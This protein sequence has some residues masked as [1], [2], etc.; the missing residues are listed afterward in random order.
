[1]QRRARRRSLQE[2]RK[3]TK[4]NRYESNR[5]LRLIQQKANLN[6]FERMKA[7][8][9]T[10]EEAV[11]VNQ[12]ALIDKIL[13]RYSTELTLFREL[14]QNANDAN[15]RQLQI[16]F[17]G[18]Q[19]WSSLSSAGSSA[20]EAKENAGSSF[21]SLRICNDGFVFREEDWERIKSIADGQ[22]DETKTGFFG[23]GFY[24]V[25]SLAEEP[26]V[27]SGKKAMSFFWKEN[28]LFV[29]RG[30]PPKVADRGNQSDQA[31]L[32]MVANGWTVFDLPVRSDPPMPKLPTITELSDFLVRCLTFTT[33]LEKVDVFM[34]DELAL[35]VSRS[36]SGSRTSIST[37]FED[38]R[39][40]KSSPFKFATAVKEPL[41]YH[42]WRCDQ[43]SPVFI[44]MMR[45]KGEFDVQ[46][47]ERFK[48]S[49]HR[50]TKK[51][52]PQK[53]SLQL[54]FDDSDD[55]S[56][57]SSA[58][59]ELI[60]NVSAAST[61]GGF[62]FIGSGITQQSTGS[63]CHCEGPFMPTMER[64]AMDM[65]DPTLA[66]WNKGLIWATGFLQRVAF[67]FRCSELTRAG[68]NADAP[69]VKS[70][71][72]S[73]M[74][75]F[76]SKATTPVQEV[77]EICSA[78]FFT[79]SR[80]PPV[81]WTSTG[82]RRASEAR[83]N[84]RTGLSNFVHQT[85]SIVELPEGLKDG[86]DES[87]SAALAKQAKSAFEFFS[88]FL[89][90]SSMSNSKDKSG[91]TTKEPLV[92][93]CKRFVGDLVD[94]GY[95]RELDVR[96]LAKELHERTLK[97]DEETVDLLKWLLQR[98][99][100]AETLRKMTE[101]DE[102]ACFCDLCGNKLLVSVA[103]LR[104]EKQKKE[105]EASSSAT[106]LFN[107]M[108][109]TLT[110]QQ[111][112]TNVA[113]KCARC[114]HVVTVDAGRLLNSMD[115]IE[116]NS[117]YTNKFLLEQ[118]RFATGKQLSGFSFF[119]TPEM[120]KRIKLS[121][122]K[123]M[124]PRIMKNFW[125]ALSLSGKVLPDVVT[126]KFMANEVVQIDK[127]WVRPLPWSE[128]LNVCLIFDASNG[129]SDER[130]AIVSNVIR[131]LAFA[132]YHG[133]INSEVK[134]YLVSR[135]A[136]TH[137]IPVQSKQLVK[138]SE[139]YFSTESTGGFKSLRVVSFV[140]L[141]EGGGFA[142]SS[143]PPQDKA[144]SKFLVELGV[145]THVDLGFVFE[146]FSKGSLGWNRQEIL[147]YI[148][149]MRKELDSMEISRLQRMEF[150][151]RIE[152]REGKAYPSLKSSKASD[153]LFPSEEL[154][155]LDVPL[156][157]AIVE[158]GLPVKKDE[159]TTNSMTVFEAHEQ[160]LPNAARNL[161][162]ELGVGLHPE[163]KLLLRQAAKPNAAEMNRGALAYIIRHF[164]TFASAYMKVCSHI[165]FIPCK[166][167]SKKSPSTCFTNSKAALLAQAVI[168]EEK[169]S[170]K[171]AEMLGVRSDPDSREV[172][173]SLA[174]NPPSSENAVEVFEYIATQL[175][176]MTRTHLHELRSVA[177]I[178]IPEPGS[179]P[180]MLRYASPQTIF[181]K[182]SGDKPGKYDGLF[183]YVSFDSQAVNLFLRS[184][185]VRD[186][187]SVD[188][189]AKELCDG[190]NA[191][192]HVARVGFTKYLHVL[193]ML[194][195]ETT[196]ISS[197]TK[198]IMSKAKFL[199]GAQ[200]VSSK[201]KKV[202]DWED[203]ELSMQAHY[204]L[205]RPKDVYI[206]DNDV[207]D[208]MF[209][210]VVAPQENIL[211]NLY[212][213]LGSQSL[214]AAVREETRPGNPYAVDSEAVSL[215][216]L[217]RKRMQLF[218]FKR[219]K[220]DFV[221][222]IEKWLTVIQK[223]QFVF[224]VP[225]IEK[226][227]HF[228]GKIKKK[229]CTAYALSHKKRALIIT[230]NYS[231]FECSTEL[232]KVLLKKNTLHDNLL[233][234]TILQ[235][236]D[237]VLREQGF[238]V[239]RN[240]VAID[241][242]VEEV[243]TPKE[244]LVPEVV[245]QREE[246]RQPMTPKVQPKSLSAFEPVKEAPETRGEA[247]ENVTPPARRR[248]FRGWMN[249]M[250]SGKGKNAASA[251]ESAPARGKSLREIY[252]EQEDTINR[253]AEMSGK[254]SPE[255]KDEVMKQAS[256]TLESDSQQ[257]QVSNP[258]QGGG[259][260]SVKNDP[261]LNRSRRESILRA[262]LSRVN[263]GGKI[264]EIVSRAEQRAMAPLLDDLH[265]HN[266]RKTRFT[267]SGLDCF[268]EVGAGDEEIFRQKSV[269]ATAFSQM[270]LWISQN[271]FGIDDPL[272]CHIYFHHEG[273][274]GAFNQSGALYFNF[275]FFLV[276]LENTGSRIYSTL[277]SNMQPKF[278]VSP[279]C[280]IDWYGIF[281]HELAHNTHHQHDAAFANMMMIFFT[282]FV[283][284][285]NACLTKLKDEIK[286][287]I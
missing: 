12:R 263:D 11:T 173:N 213:S 106:G 183:P 221:R 17:Q 62:F 200:H 169:L 100:T 247:S 254:A 123:G 95:L 104:K 76:S 39:T 56:V 91:E 115:K 214:S 118:A 60:K 82:A 120:L 171:D 114:A 271:I 109:A 167:G 20:V 139:A 162:R 94:R 193:R 180:S 21:S 141:L 14:L 287:A 124:E 258:P 36:S 41:L 234:S 209:E 25:F 49:M 122:E 31:I 229:S 225:S 61:R 175:P 261:L 276:Q 30:S 110:G 184:V 151:P 228:N 176:K 279:D 43:D 125:E 19:F 190:R 165:D 257:S 230:A 102:I 199:V 146:E 131:I 45:I 260:G 191:E 280:V 196:N 81:V 4:L 147:H 208:R 140:H 202:E 250:I 9:A 96:D 259:F 210:P 24:S 172:A 58:A 231:L 192:A 218:F 232:C 22:P 152:I 46:V 10:V 105:R 136:A 161:L 284:P 28:A 237:E 155:D 203:G 277:D 215:E 111:E 72:L 163:V 252:G 108:T 269:E 67:E 143:E 7:Q 243:Q 224:K 88:T 57:E 157:H 75:T 80:T 186:E 138:P 86:S 268:V 159:A 148:A 34:D 154:V 29:R 189:L 246:I 160:S 149:S 112:T 6:R 55:N 73:S 233:W 220:S 2:R 198:R 42:V 92:V 78:G 32:E 205:C 219:D 236:P 121:S 266:L 166:D 126:D 93:L 1:V 158:E 15:A 262:N 170:R 85:A 201:E 103:S 255:M 16:R 211:E 188:E 278:L 273:A 64:N 26:S 241:K 182:E 206:N 40:P 59:W 286:E 242:P 18:T 174:T 119:L 13:A 38:M 195:V 270:L 168:D 285:L 47:G 52:P 145:K 98:G 226:T 248:S 267:F 8:G 142:S 63:K 84:D 90:G 51:N 187:P 212:H 240:I 281:C 65:S 101:S 83:I 53:V 264:Q 179:K 71:V 283:E 5:S 116:V 69:M 164:D 77:G 113:V 245:E 256:K 54:I 185:G 70:R 244:V 3:K 156:V 282:S 27:L 74:A 130:L 117:N 129:V 235:S 275:F 251:S 217:I 37:P 48:A 35:S 177:F 128:W 222:D 265:E 272:V 132:V 89:A 135:L 239:K 50:V 207:I 44:R 144:V 238:P 66:A 134:T 216:R 23:V 181:F 133:E 223:E 107:R 68:A 194:A 87:G 274:T 227:L 249:S 97:D 197:S 253:A 99:K 137:C 127:N 33:T 178:P 150:L 79:C 204:H 153:L